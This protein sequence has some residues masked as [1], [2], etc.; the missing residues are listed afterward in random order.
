[1][2][3]NVTT[4]SAA[5]A[6]EP[7][8]AAKP[9]A[10]NLTVRARARQMTQSRTRQAPAPS[11][12]PNQTP[13][14]AAAQNSPAPA[15]ASREETPQPEATADAP[16]PVLPATPAPEPAPAPTPGASADPTTPDPAATPAVASEEPGD[17]SAALALLDGD[18]TPD[19]TDET[20]P[21]AGESNE[22][23]LA[24]LDTLLKSGD[25]QGVNKE[26][27]KRV[28]QT[29]DRFKTAEAELAEANRRLAERTA[30]PAR[31]EAATSG[32]PALDQLDAQIHQALSSIE[33]MDSHLAAIAQAQASGEEIP[34]HLTLAN[35]EVWAD[36]KGRPVEVT[37]EKARQ[38]ARQ[39]ELQLS[40]LNVRRETTATQL[41]AAHRETARQSMATAAQ[42]YPWLK[43]AKAPEYQALQTLLRTNP[44]LKARSDWPEVAAD[45]IAGRHARLARAGKPAIAAT[46]PPLQRPKGSPTPPPVGA[47]PGAAV[48]GLARDGRDTMQ[49]QVQAARERFRKTGSVKDRAALS[50]LERQQRSAA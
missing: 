18:G 24:R 29:T 14:P 23:W 7:T 11:A 27:L 12:A 20:E 26:L 38:W 42:A 10:Q 3:T 1:M 15:P 6:A 8:A 22:Q 17:D 43:N 45:Y 46:A 19:T 47:Q 2:D 34:K 21:A 33:L 30:E 31:A 35:G 41:E 49:Q 36:A 16:A 44:G 48:A 13:A 32:H 37:P 5:P 40:Q 50:A 4:T 25:A 39:Y 28:H 9:S